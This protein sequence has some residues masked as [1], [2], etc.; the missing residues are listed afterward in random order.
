[1]GDSISRLRDKNLIV[2][3]LLNVFFLKETVGEFPTVLKFFIKSKKAGATVQ[4]SYIGLAE[5]IYPKT[6]C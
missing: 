5:S 3:G 1:M 2:K 6:E 4:V